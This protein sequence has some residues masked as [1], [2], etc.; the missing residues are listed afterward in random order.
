LAEVRH[1]P[2]MALIPLGQQIQGIADPSNSTSIEA[3]P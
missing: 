1:A 3:F 2:S